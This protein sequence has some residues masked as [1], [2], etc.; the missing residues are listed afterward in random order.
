[1]NPSEATS[2]SLSL[3]Y[4]WALTLHVLE[5]FTTYF[6]RIVCQRFVFIHVFEQ[7]FHGGE[8][9]VARATYMLKS[10]SVVLKWWLFDR[11]SVGIPRTLRHMFVWNRDAYFNDNKC[12]LF[13]FHNSQFTLEK[14]YWHI[15]SI[16]LALPY[17][18]FILP[19]PDSYTD[20]EYRFLVAHSD[21]TYMGPGPGL[22]QCQ[23]IGPV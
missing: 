9:L 5:C 17:G 4:K 11:L 15:V 6:T 16:S 2:L 21:R 19:D 7:L 13:F 14:M 8:S 10:I 12:C 22:I 3:Q 23:S 1:M 18:V 20:T